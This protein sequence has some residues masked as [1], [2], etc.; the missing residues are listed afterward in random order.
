M[1]KEVKDKLG[2]FRQEYNISRHMQMARASL[3]LMQDIILSQLEK[4]LTIRMKEI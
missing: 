2:L 4:M 1:Y 3:T